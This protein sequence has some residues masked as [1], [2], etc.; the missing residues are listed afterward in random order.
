MLG[1]QHSFNASARVFN[2]SESFE[3]KI[4]SGYIAQSSIAKWIARAASSL[5][6]LRN[7]RADSQLYVCENTDPFHL[8]GRAGTVRALPAAQEPKKY[9]SQKAAGLGLKTAPAVG[10]QDIRR[11]E[12][13]RFPNGSRARPHNASTLHFRSADRFECA[14]YIPLHLRSQ[15]KLEP[16]P[17]THLR[18]RLWDRNHLPEFLRTAVA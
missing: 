1:K 9:C 4:R 6:A 8:P 15:H 13:R 18:S 2:Q 16:R 11:P 7:S 10:L 14:P 3:I 12:P 5:K 17:R